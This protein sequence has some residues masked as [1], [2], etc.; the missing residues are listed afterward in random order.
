MVYVNSIVFFENENDFISNCEEDS[1][2]DDNDIYQGWFVFQHCGIKKPSSFPAA[3]KYEVPQDP[4]FGG[5]YVEVD[6]ATY[7]KKAIEYQERKIEE[8]NRDIAIL[9]MLQ[10]TTE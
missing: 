6:Y 3:F 2:I 9:K 1:Y 5:S 8:L 7:A 4:H 10:S